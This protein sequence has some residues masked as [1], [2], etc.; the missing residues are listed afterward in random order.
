M[1][2]EQFCHKLCC[3]INYL[4]AYTVVSKLCLTLIL[5]YGVF[6]FYAVITVIPQNKNEH[7]HLEY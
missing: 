2:C 6:H 3:F 5:K 7:R 1:N 4:N